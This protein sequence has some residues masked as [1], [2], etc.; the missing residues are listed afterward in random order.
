[1]FISH[2]SKAGVGAYILSEAA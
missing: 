1:M 2:D